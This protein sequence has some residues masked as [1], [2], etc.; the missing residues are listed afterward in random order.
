MFEDVV[1]KS[2]AAIIN[3]FVRRNYVR[4]QDLPVLINLTQESIRQCISEIYSGESVIGRNS[5]RLAES[6]SDRHVCLECGR[7]SKNLRVHLKQ[8]HYTNAIKY[9]KKWGVKIP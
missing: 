6:P 1:A 7:T 9:E 5:P 3:G 2:S 4:A 8:R